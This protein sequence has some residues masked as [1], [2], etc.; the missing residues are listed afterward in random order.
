MIRRT[1]LLQLSVVRK[2]NSSRSSLAICRNKHFQGRFGGSSPHHDFKPAVLATVSRSVQ[3]SV[4]ITVHVQE[5][6]FISKCLL[7]KSGQRAKE[8]P[9]VVRIGLG[10]TKQNNAALAWRQGGNKS[11]NQSQSPLQLVSEVD[12]PKICKQAT[13][14]VQ[15]NK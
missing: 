15:S 10:M 4:S 9:N 2:G 7:N 3:P 8:Q 6:C 14:N 5:G 13:G 12:R 1:I 11:I